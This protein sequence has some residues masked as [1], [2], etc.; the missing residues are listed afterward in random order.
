MPAER[1]YPVIVFDWDGT[2]IDSADAIVA[3]IQAAAR[4]LALPVPDGTRARHVIGLGLHDSLRHAVPSLPTEQYAE[5]A[6]RYRRHFV[7]REPALQLFAG[8]PE[9]LQRLRARGHRLAVATGKSRR[10]LE[11]ALVSSG[12]ADCFAASRCGDETQPKPHPA[13]LQELMH[14][15]GAAAESALMIGDTSHDLQMARSAGIASLGVTYG[16]HSA[17]ALR[18]LAPLDCI[19]SVAELDRWLAANA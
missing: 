8:V 14:E 11:R 6:E 3:C 1:R 12:L 4:E 16:A 18:M 15:M 13:M 2:L 17:A 5:F 10:G 9:L 19:A 7:A